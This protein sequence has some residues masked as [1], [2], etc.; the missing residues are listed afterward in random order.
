MTQPCYYC[1]RVIGNAPYSTT[2]TEGLY[3]YFH[4]DCY[5][6][7]LVREAAEKMNDLLQEYLDKEFNE[8]VPTE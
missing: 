3:V 6:D 2:L 4:P 1:R 5:Q 7:A 8:D